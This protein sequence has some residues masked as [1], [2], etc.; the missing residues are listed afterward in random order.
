MGLSNIALLI[1]KTASQ[2]RKYPPVASESDC[3][4]E[5]LRKDAGNNLY[6]LLFWIIAVEIIESDLQII[7]H[8]LINLDNSDNEEENQSDEVIHAY[9][10]NKISV[11]EKDINSS[12]PKIIALYNCQELI[13]NQSTGKLGKLDKLEDVRPIYHNLPA[14]DCSS[15]IGR[16]T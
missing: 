1:F 3:T 10:I 16:D 13:K 7:L 2:G 12:L 4:T 6:S 8:D 9:Y 14:R 5:Y 15:F 11:E